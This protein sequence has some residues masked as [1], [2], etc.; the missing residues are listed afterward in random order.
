MAKQA[1]EIVSRIRDEERRTI[2]K[3]EDNPKLNENEIFPG[4][5]FNVAKNHMEYFP[6]YSE[7]FT[8]YENRN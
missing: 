8:D 1:C 3:T 5:M 6:L 7:G 4:M 2:W